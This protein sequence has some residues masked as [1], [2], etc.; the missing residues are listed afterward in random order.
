[1]SDALVVGL[2]I[3]GLV[4]LVTFVLAIGELDIRHFDHKMQRE[5]GRPLSGAEKQRLRHAFYDG[6]TFGPSVR[7]M[8]RR[9]R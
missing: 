5:F 6:L 1:M 2:C 4:L 8:Q 9:R 3:G 7:A